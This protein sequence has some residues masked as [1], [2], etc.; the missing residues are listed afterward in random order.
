MITASRSFLF[1]IAAAAVALTVEPAMSHDDPLTAWGAAVTAIADPRMLKASPFPMNVEDHFSKRLAPG[2]TKDQGPCS[3]STWV[4]DYV[5]HIAAAES[6]GPEM[7]LY[8]GNPPVKVPNRDLS[9]VVTARG[10]RLGDTPAKVVKALQF[11][12]SAVTRTSNDRGYLYL[13]KPVYLSDDVSH[14]KYFDIAM[15]LFR[16]GRVVSIWFVHDEN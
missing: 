5:H 10:I 13:S 9:H 7:I 2:G 6:G 12:L 8:A 3:G 16:D 15:I 14:Y 4:Y 1:A 11:P